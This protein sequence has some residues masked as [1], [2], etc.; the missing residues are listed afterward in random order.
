MLVPYHAPPLTIE[1]VG[2]DQLSLTIEATD[3]V[4]TIGRL[5][6]P[7]LLVG[8]YLVQ[9]FT[10]DQLVGGMTATVL[11][12]FALV[13]IGYLGYRKV[14]LVNRSRRRAEQKTS[15]FGVSWP[16][17]VS[18]GDRPTAE[19]K[20]RKR[21]HKSEGRTITNYDYAA[22]LVG[23]EALIVGPYRR[24]HEAA[25]ADVAPLEAFLAGGS[26]PETA[27]AVELAPD[28]SLDAWTYP[29]A[30]FEASGQC[31]FCRD[32]LEPPADLICCEQCR[33]GMHR[34]C[35]QELGSCP[36]LGCRNQGRRVPA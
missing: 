14:T 34:E 36:T 30:P 3:L 33:T 27:R 10:R 17:R 5:A 25:A 35:A 23:R 24:H 4:R 21:T 8:A 15:F 18:L 20:T 7:A 12:L 1:E 32:P 22:R 16:V 13:L 9:R 11:S 26:R 31:P 29:L 28:K 19:V 6:I 2:P